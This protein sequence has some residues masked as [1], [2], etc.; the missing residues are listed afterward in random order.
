MST[1]VERPTIKLEFDRN[2]AIAFAASILLHGLF[3][4]AIA[5][6]V[7]QPKSTPPRKPTIYLGEITITHPKDPNKHVRIGNTL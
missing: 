1:L 5:S 7:G 4:A 2:L 3:L 6:V